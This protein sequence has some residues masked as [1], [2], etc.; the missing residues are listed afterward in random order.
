MDNYEYPEIYHDPYDLW[1]SKFGVIVRRQFYDGQN[2]AKVVALLIAVIDWLAPT[3]A[4][5]AFLI[6]GQKYPIVEA[7]K[8]LSF[9]NCSND[10]INS[11]V[12]N[13]EHLQAQNSGWGL[14]FDWQSKNGFYDV[15]T[16]FI[17]HTPYVLEALLFSF[18]KT[19]SKKS[20]T[21]FLNSSAFLETLLVMHETETEL[22][23][24]YAPQ[25]EPRIVVNANSYA[26]LTY[27]LHCKFGDKSQS[28]KNRK[29]A[30]KILEWV[31][32]QQN[33]DGSWFYYADHEAGNFIDCFHSCFIV[34]NLITIRDLLD[35]E[36]EKLTTGITHGFCFI[37]DTFYIEEKGLC[38]K[39]VTAPYLNFFRWDLYDQAEYV[40]LLIDLG[41][42]T[43]ASDMVQ[44]VKN[45]FLRNGALHCKIDI[46]GR[47]WGKNYL[48]WG[49]MAFVYN[50]QRLTNPREAEV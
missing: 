34:K 33:L 21:L 7:Q 11:I 46:L 24:S 10:Y 30:L 13:L 37:R 45:R 15:T 14:G 29:K 35:F 42:I 4:R 12:E 2:A 19:K 41:F 38:K 18:E 23:L 17:T 22:A 39:F 25:A 5:W 6:K 28:E 3:F 44:S 31:L 27:A 26:A 47:R 43:E 32:N 20:Y 8:L 9:T 36:N 49:I 40:G 1:S 50:Q 48:R 16:S